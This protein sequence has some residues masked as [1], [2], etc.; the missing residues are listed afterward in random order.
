MEILKSLTF[1]IFS[2]S[3]VS[4]QL[5]WRSYTSIRRYGPLWFLI[6]SLESLRFTDK[7]KLCLRMW[8]RKLT[9]LIFREIWRWYW[10]GE[11]SSVPRESLIPTLSC[12]NQDLWEC[13]DYFTPSI[14]IHTSFPVLLAE[15]QVSM[16]GLTKWAAGDKFG[17]TK[18]KIGWKKS[19]RT[20]RCSKSSSRMDLDE[21][22]SIM[23]LKLRRCIKNS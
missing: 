6:L 4:I 23:L 21:M 17:A 15:R 19:Q 18:N 11:F 20:W 3:S 8:K 2:L 9:D 22:L 1:L 16:L 5:T 13:A 10:L 7:L 14:T 12:K